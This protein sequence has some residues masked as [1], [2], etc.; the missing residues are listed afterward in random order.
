MNYKLS[1]YIKLLENNGLI[2]EKNA[3]ENND[4]SFV[5]YNSKEACTGTL[6]IC[7]GAHFKEEYLYD[8]KKAGAVCY[9]SEKKYDV[10]MDCI[11]VNNIRRTMPVVFNMFY[12]SVWKKLKLIGITGTK[13]KSTTTYFIKY[14]L[15]EYLKSMNKPRSAFMSS[16]DTYD[17]V[18]SFESHLTTPE[19]GELFRHFSNAVKSNID[20]LTMEV[21]SQALKYDRVYG[22][23]FDIG[24]YL[25]IGEDHISDIEHPDFDDYFRSKMMLFNQCKTACVSLDTLR[26]DDV[27]KA[28]SACEKVVTF[29][30]M[31]EN[32]DI[33]AYDI[34]KSGNDTVFMVRTPEYTEEITLTIPGLF[35]VQNALAAI[36][37]CY[38]LKIP[39]HYIYVGLMKARSSGRMEIYAN[40]DNRV[41][42]IVDYA[43]NKL[44]FQSLYDSVTKEFPSRKIITVFGCPGKKA[45]QR[46]KDLG[47]LSGKYSDFVY[48]TE[49]DHGEEPLM[50]ICEEIAE[51]VKAQGCRFEIEPDRGQAIKKAIFSADRDTVV[52]ITG[53]GNETR[54]K[55][56]T[57]YIPC[58]SDVEY[59]KKF[60][61]EFD[62]SKKIDASEKISSFQSVLPA[63]RKL[64]GKTIVVKT[65]G[66]IMESEAALRDIYEDIAL[67]KMVGARVVIVH[68]GGK[69][70]SAALEKNGIK[71]EFCGGYRV[72]AK[73][74]VEI[75]EQV[76]SGG[77]NKSIVQGL[78]NEGLNAC[79]ISGK[80]AGLITAVKKEIPEGDIGFVGEI[81]KVNPQILKLMLENNYIPVISPVST[82]VKGETLNVNADDAAFAVAEALKADTLVFLTDVDGILLDINNESTIIN[83]ISVD[84]AKDL[85]ENGFIG[86]GM[87]PKL[88]SCISSIENG[89]S[90]VAIINGGI[91]Y[92]L[93]T[94]F[95]TKG[96]TG[97]TI[98][99]NG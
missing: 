49:E 92:N 48:I 11:I 35:N 22:V 5:T 67:L 77:V 47:E 91:K 30:S 1:E 39:K 55:R 31:D 79:G 38:C 34:K 98:N 60:L 37:V 88:K 70:I 85:L 78:K 4:I 75:V 83:S 90:E 33:F 87:L 9:I 16:I 19:A 46:R 74:A 65:G 51:H 99:I 63:F 59:T 6:F 3:N 43:H 14:I 68:G 12:D 72:T 28:A 64:Y 24:V 10:D 86:G 36:A 29:S 23:N 53:K 2:S 17:G 62:I 93:I 52:L 94:Y 26:V 89:V 71:A 7:K 15:D 97:T 57:Q 58:P 21:S 45:F 50:Q 44:S 69:K 32:A 25:N 42:A 96:K 13:G 20:Y 40:S 95:I 84:R 66:S 61:K 54:Q 27:L 8:A 81:D 80:D 82:S 73:N 41:I 76:L 18:E 56:G